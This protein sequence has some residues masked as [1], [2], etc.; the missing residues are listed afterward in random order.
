MQPRSEQP[1][2]VGALLTIASEA[3][4]WAFPSA[5]VLSVET[6]ER[7]QAEP[8]AELLALLGAPSPASVHEARVLVLEAGGERR[9][10]RVHGALELLEGAA[11]QLLPLPPEVRATSPL[12]SHVAVVDGKPTSFVVSPERLFES[13]R[14]VPTL[15][16]SPEAVRGT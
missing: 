4:N 10:V 1:R 13:L 16:S 9:R 7:Q 2:R 12:L 11:V 6:A 8:D 3:G 15:P 5:A 14:H